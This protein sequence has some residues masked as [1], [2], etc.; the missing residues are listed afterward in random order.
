MLTCLYFHLEAKLAPKAYSNFVTKLDDSL[1]TLE[2]EGRHPFPKGIS[3]VALFKAHE[4]QII[5]EYL[6]RILNQFDLMIIREAAAPFVAYYAWHTFL[7]AEHTAT[8]LANAPAVLAELQTQ[9]ELFK[10]VQASEFGFEKFEELRHYAKAIRDFGHPSNFTA[11]GGEHSHTYLAKQPFGKSNKRDPLDQVC[12][13]MLTFSRLS[14]SCIFLR[15]VADQ[16][17]LKLFFQYFPPITRTH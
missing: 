7:Y 10:H 15:G 14:L 6:P 9:L 4:L 5:S 8:Q 17:K 3:H 13:F 12:G 1:A 11:E 16:G 2:I